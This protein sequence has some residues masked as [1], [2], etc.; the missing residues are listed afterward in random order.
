LAD[1]NIQKIDST[2]LRRRA[3]EQLGEEAA[4]EHLFGAKEDPRKL[5]HEL[6]VHQIELETQNTELRQ[7]REDEAAALEQYTDLYNFAPVGYFTLDREGTI[8][9]VNFTAAGLVGVERSQLVGRRFGLLVVEEARPAFADFLGRVFASLAKETCE[10]PLLKEGNSPLFVKIEA[11]AAASGQKC[12]IALLDITESTLVSKLKREEEIAKTTIGES[13]ELALQTVEDAVEEAFEKAVWITELPQNNEEINIDEARLK[14]EEAAKAARLKV[15]EAAEE[16]RLKVAKAANT[17][18]L[19]NETTEVVNQ[20]VIKA[21]EIARQ[22]VDKA[23][24]VARR[25]VLAAVALQKSERKFKAVAD[26][27]GL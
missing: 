23:L 14:M 2:E 8:S 19:D 12:R 3:E 21:A 9:R 27:S 13:V 11:V 1:N 7:A 26:T 6:Q 17:L 18:Q 24:K 22:K 10:V 25:I 20:K 15:K 5:L 16:A 4:T